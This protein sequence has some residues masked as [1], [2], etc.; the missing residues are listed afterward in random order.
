M[1]ISIVSQIKSSL[2]SFRNFVII[3]VTSISAN[4]YAYITLEPIIS[5]LPVVLLSTIAIAAI[6][7]LSIQLPALIKVYKTSLRQISSS[8]PP[9]LPDVSVV[10][11]ASGAASRLPELLEVLMT[12]DY[13]GNYEVIVVND[14]CDPS[15]DDIMLLSE[16]RWPN[17]SHTFTPLGTRNLSPRK[18]ALTLG[19]KAAHNEIIVHTTADTI[20]TSSH[21]LSSMSAPFL[22]SE[23]EIVTGVSTINEPISNT[24]IKGAFR[25]HMSLTDNVLMQHA[26]LCNRAFTGDAN[27]L[28]Y[29]RELFFRQR[30]FSNSLDIYYGDDDV[31]VN[32]SA[33][34]DN[35]R[36]V[37]SSDSIVLT[38]GNGIPGYYRNLRLKRAFT[39]GH[40]RQR[41]RMIFN[42]SIIALYIWLVTSILSVVLFPTNYIVSSVVATAL[43]GLW[44][45]L[46]IYWNKCARLLQSRQ[47]KFGLPL[48]LFTLPFIKL[49]YRLRCKSVHKSITDWQSLNH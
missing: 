29:R 1:L 23:I 2:C 15:T 43:L 44:I 6:A 49:K 7:V 14:G 40:V 46:F 27:N 47:L 39:S 9:A 25:S 33:T 8:T 41:E 19:V 5:L 20:P 11:Y 35:T 30:G 16:S 26:T 10:V 24:G 32:D 18:L 17:L 12:Q 42:L 38:T 45:P 36:A 31:F 37:I 3:P 21:W 48:F 28:A 13:N 4:H 22:D 34:R